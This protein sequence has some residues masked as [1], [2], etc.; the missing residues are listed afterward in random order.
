[1]LIRM[2]VFEM[3]TER[4]EPVRFGPWQHIETVR[5]QAVFG[6]SARLLNFIKIE[7]KQAITRYS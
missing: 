4:L 3:K 2:I 5:L 1:L 7:Q 6:I